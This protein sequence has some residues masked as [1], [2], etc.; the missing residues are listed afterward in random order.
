MYLDQCLLVAP[1]CLEGLDMAFGST[2]SEGGHKVEQVLV[3]EPVAHEPLLQSVEDRSMRVHLCWWVLCVR[4]LLALWKPLGAQDSNN[5]ER[6]IGVLP[7]ARWC[8]LGYAIAQLTVM[9]H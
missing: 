2:R 3:Q 8:Q 4:G 5:F 7:C 6:R 1:H 9:A